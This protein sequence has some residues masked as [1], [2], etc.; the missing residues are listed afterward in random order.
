LEASGIIKTKRIGN[1]RYKYV[2]L[3]HPTAV[4]EKLRLAGKVD[5]DWLD[6]YK[7]RQLETK[8]LTLDARKKAPVAP[9]VVPIKPSNP[10]AAKATAS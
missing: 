8:E 1:Q 9:K 10:A 4:V 2:L 3:I 5:D 7:D 6:T